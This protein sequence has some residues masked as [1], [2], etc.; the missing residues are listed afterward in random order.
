MKKYKSLSED[1]IQKFKAE[2]SEE[3]VEVIKNRLYRTE[4]SSQKFQT[5]P[6]KQ[7]HF[8]VETF[9]EEYCTCEHPY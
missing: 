9:L 7:S 2:L 1:F 6:Q 4:N 8:K 5:Q 3:E